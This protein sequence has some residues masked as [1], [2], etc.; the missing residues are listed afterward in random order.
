MQAQRERLLRAV[1]AAAV[2]GEPNVSRVAA[3]ARAGRAS[4]YEFFDDFEHALATVRATAITSLERALNG[5][6]ERERA[7]YAALRALAAE[8]LATIRASP[9]ASLC[10][11]APGAGNASALGACFAR[12]LEGWLSASSGAGFITPRSDERRLL[13]A[14]GAA[15]AFA[16]RTALTQL[17]RGSTDTDDGR[18]LADALMRLLR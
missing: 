3:L 6:L 14:T 8:L 9:E 1:A 2:E 18:V 12:A 13:L 5:A 15:E 4:F 11:L 10:A 7:P 17:S 16:R